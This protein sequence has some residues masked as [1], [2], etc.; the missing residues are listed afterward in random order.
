MFVPER[1]DV[2]LRGSQDSGFVVRDAVTQ[3]LLSWRLDFSEAL[4]LAR[5][6]GARIVWQQVLDDRGRPLGQPRPLP[7][8]NWD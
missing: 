1:G 8:A 7:D 2:L 3:E 6:R 5:A 4:A